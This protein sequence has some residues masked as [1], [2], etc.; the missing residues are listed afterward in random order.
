M[1]RWKYHGED[2]KRETAYVVITMAEHIPPV[3]GGWTSTSP[4]EASLYVK[5]KAMISDVLP[6]LYWTLVSQVN[7]F[8]MRFLNEVYFLFFEHRYDNKITDVDHAPNQGR[9]RMNPPCI[10]GIGGGFVSK[11][12]L[13]LI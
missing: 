4:A 10:V 1:P 6:T 13:I 3:V 7:M 2:D 12:D 11:S 9:D 8:L 5:Q